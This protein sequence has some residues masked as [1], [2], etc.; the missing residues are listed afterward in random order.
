MTRWRGEHGIT[1][2]GKKDMVIKVAYEK[3]QTFQF[4]A[5]DLINK[6]S[7]NDGI[8]VWNAVQE[9]TM[10]NDEPINIAEGKLSLNVF[11]RDVRESD[12]YFVRYETTDGKVHL[13]PAIYP[14]A[15]GNPTVKTKILRTAVNMETTA[16]HSGIAF[17]GTNEFLTPKSQIPVQKDSVVTAEVSKLMERASLWKFEEN[18]VDSLGEYQIN[19]LKPHMFVAGSREFGKSLKFTGVEKIMLPRR[20]WN[21]GGFGT[22]SFDIKPESIDGVKRQCIIFK[23]GSYDGFS[24]NLMPD[25]TI[26]IIRSH[27]VGESTQNAGEN[28]VSSEKIKVNEWNNIKIIADAENMQIFVNGKASQKFKLLPLRTYGNG[29]VHLGGGYWKANNFKGLIDNLCIKG[30]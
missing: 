29:L 16:G 10:L 8:A 18:G 19:G 3:G 28:F 20:H 9:M 25:G 11:N 23:D 26:E 1:F 24:I 21:L 22:I 27:G 5:L 12:S 13:T 14:F 17:I 7:L 6:R 4:S 2:I 30:F 15:N